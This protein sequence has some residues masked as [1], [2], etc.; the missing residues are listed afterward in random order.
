VEKAAK[1]P[2]AKATTPNTNVSG[3]ENVQ[4]SQEALGLQGVTDRLKEMPVVDSEKVARLKAAVADGSY[5]VD[6][7]KVA[8]KLL[9]FENER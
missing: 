6:S 1:A 7:Q 9:A 8:S 5:Q 2:E 4:L 3:G